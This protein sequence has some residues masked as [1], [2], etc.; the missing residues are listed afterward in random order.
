MYVKTLTC[1]MDAWI[2][3]ELQDIKVAS[4]HTATNAV[5]TGDVGAL[6]LYRE[7]S[8]HHLLISMVLEF[9]G[10]GKQSPMPQEQCSNPN[11]TTA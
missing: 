2:T 8:A 9:N 10:P 4:L 6:A 5:D 3:A 7:Q 1:F 11:Y